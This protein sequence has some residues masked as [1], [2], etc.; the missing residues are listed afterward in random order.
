MR[1]GSFLD[2]AEAAKVKDPVRFWETVSKTFAR[3]DNPHSAYRYHLLARLRCPSYL[4]LNFDP[5]LIDILSL[6]GNV[7]VSV[8]PKVQDWKHGDGEV[9]HLH[10]RVPPDH[11]G[12]PVDLVLTRTDFERAYN[13][14]ESMLHAFL[15]STL[16]NNDLCFIGCNPAEE[17]LQRILNACRLIRRQVYGLN[18][19]S[20][21][22]WYLLQ[23]DSATPPPCLREAGIEIV[24][25]PKTDAGYVGLDKILEY[26]ADKRDP[27]VRVP[28]VRRQPFDP[29]T[30]PQR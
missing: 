30:E 22:R 28:G 29:A 11:R 25:Y 26:W 24:E 9:F 19:P 4:T 13:P 27:V 10:G 20:P 14:F 21:P 23:D 2:L 5:L 16:M 18:Y 1:S 7:T 8:Y 15:Q 12:G 17:N 3:R 6:H